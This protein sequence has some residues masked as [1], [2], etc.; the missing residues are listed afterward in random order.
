MSYDDKVLLRDVFTPSSPARLAFVERS[1][2]NEKLV[3][4]LQTTGKQLVVYGHSGSGKTTI[5]VNKLQQLYPAHLTSRC[6]AHMTFE[7]L[8]LNAFG[9]LDSFYTDEC[10]VVDRKS[11]S[12]GLKAEY[13]G[14]KAQVGAYLDRQSKVTVKRIV[15]PQLTI[16]TLARLLGPAGVCWVLEDFHKLPD[17]EK[18]KLSNATKVFMDEADIY[19]D[20]KIIAIGAVDTARQVVE[21]DPEMRH[22]IAEIEVPLMTRNEIRQI[23][24][25]GEKLLNIHIP[26]ELREGIVYYSNGLA[27]ICHTLCQNLCLVQ[28]IVETQS[29]LREAS[30]RHF[31][32]AVQRYLEDASDTLKAAFDL[33]FRQQRTRRFDNCKLII[34]ALSKL[35]QE[36]GNHSKILK[37]IRRVESKYPSGNLTRYLRQLQTPERGSLIRYD[38]QAGTYSFADPIFRTYAIA[39]LK[40]ASAHLPT[41]LLSERWDSKIAITLAKTIM[42][43]VEKVRVDKDS[44]ATRMY[45]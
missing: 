10:S 26:D 42:K 14:L 1:S 19:K 17:V 23:A 9:Q 22:R 12:S 8:L 18:K 20:L 41:D 21:F 31:E 29:T 36:G 27:S 28:G 6:V 37:T 25:K 5:L 45:R 35:P 2:V 32:Q 38:R 39:K 34:Q 7:H 4:A 16:Q 33:A 15:P 30:H 43:Q 24:I 11:I 13:L 44:S 40:R 3:N